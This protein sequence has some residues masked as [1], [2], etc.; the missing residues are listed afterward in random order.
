MIATLAI[1]IGNALYGIKRG[2]FRGL[3]RLGTILLAMVGAFY[4]SR[5][6]S[7]TAVTVLEPWLNKTLSS[8]V[9]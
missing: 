6:L 7:G 4:L 2:F 3:L 1:L 5:V 8:N 9:R